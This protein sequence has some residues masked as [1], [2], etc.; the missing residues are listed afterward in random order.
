MRKEIADYIYSRSE[1][2]Q[3]LR[4][5]PQWYRILSRRPEDLEKFEIQSLHYFKRTI[6]HQM[7]KFSNGIQIA[8]MMM[9]MLPFIQN[10]GNQEPAE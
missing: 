2:R 5:Q 3:F 6:P 1:L 10:N 7:E 9:G 8:K 4:E